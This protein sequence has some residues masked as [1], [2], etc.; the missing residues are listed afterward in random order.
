M[1]HNKSLGSSKVMLNRHN[2]NDGSV[3][4]ENMQ[5]SMQ[6]Q[7]RLALEMDT[8]SIKNM[9]FNT[10]NNDSILQNTVDRKKYNN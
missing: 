9:V 6:K 4:E 1:M 3:I 2:F 10:H 5:Y 8:G 7:S